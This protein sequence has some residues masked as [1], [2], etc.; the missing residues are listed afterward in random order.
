M[1][2][3]AMSLFVYL[4]AQF[5]QSFT[6]VSVDWWFTE[7]IIHYLILSFWL[8]YHIE[9][10]I[11]D[12]QVNDILQHIHPVATAIGPSQSNLFHF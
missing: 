11:S 3:I 4:F 6:I 8:F 2:P 12:I 7:V 9:S 1:S 5:E 10:I